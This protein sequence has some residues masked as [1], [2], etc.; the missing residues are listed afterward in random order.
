MKNL[1]KYRESIHLNQLA[2]AM[3]IGVA[4]ETIS[5]YESGRSNPS[6]STLLKLC[7]ELDVSAD[8]LLDRTN[9]PISI[10]RF[11]QK[12]LSEEELG[13]LS[14]YRKLPVTKQK[15]AVGFLMGMLYRED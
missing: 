9:V 11:L 13:M 2:L 14:V 3:R 12:D 7:D 4:Q 8:F 5:A 6:I 1:Q 15:H 10:E